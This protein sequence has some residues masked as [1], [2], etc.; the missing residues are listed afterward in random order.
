[1]TFQRIKVNDRVTFP[2]VVNFNE[3]LHGYENIENKLY[4]KEVERMQQ[5]KKE[6][7]EK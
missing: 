2:P 5:Y 1:M 4:D 7:T 3:Y 6:I